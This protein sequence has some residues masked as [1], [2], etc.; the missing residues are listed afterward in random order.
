MGRIPRYGYCALTADFLHIGHIRFLKQCKQH[1]QFLIVGIMTDECVQKYKKKKPIMT[2]EQRKEIIESLEF[3]A[4]T[5]PQTT[6]EFP[7]SLKRSKIIFGKDL[8]IFDNKRH[9]RRGADML[10]PYMEG[11]SSTKFRRSYLL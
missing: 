1:C 9:N 2:Y 3:V 10:F 5:H 4:L 7:D 6:F 8:I 11:I